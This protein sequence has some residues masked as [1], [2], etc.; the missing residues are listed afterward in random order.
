MKIDWSFPRRIAIAIVI[1]IIFG[2]YPLFTVWDAVTIEAI[3]VGMALATLNVILG[4]AAIEYSIGKSTTTFFKYV[5]G[6]MGL[7]LVLL[8]ILLVILIKIFSLPV[9]ALV[10]SMGIF[11]MVFL[12]LEVLYIQRKI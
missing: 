4:Y 8:S 10:G 1:M 7:R 2:A 3:F 11:Y 5:I 12:V 9:L 6:G